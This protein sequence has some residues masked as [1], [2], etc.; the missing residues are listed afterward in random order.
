[1]FRKGLFLEGNSLRFCLLL[2]LSRQ[3]AVA[4]PRWFS[5]ATLV[6]VSGSPSS[7]WV[8]LSIDR[9]TAIF[10]STSLSSAFICC[11]VF[12]SGA[13]SGFAI[14]SCRSC[15]LS[16]DS[17]FALSLSVFSSSGPVINICSVTPTYIQHITRFRPSVSPRRLRARGTTMRSRHAPSMER[18]VVPFVSGRAEF[19]TCREFE[20]LCGC[21]GRPSEARRDA[22][23]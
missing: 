22:S 4:F 13:S 15:C 2:S 6:S 3:N 19:S 14:S 8:S 23:A 12:G 9:S 5:I 18:R 21:R 10:S 20:N 11:G 16:D 17:T 7:R 1:M